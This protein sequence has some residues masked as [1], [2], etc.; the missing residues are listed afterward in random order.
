[1]NKT[2]I[3]FL[4][5]CFKV[6]CLDV[7]SQGERRGI[8]NA[9]IAE[10]IYLQLDKAIYTTGSTIWF[11]SIVTSSYNNSLTE[12]SSVLHVELIG[13][14]KNTIEKKLI[15]LNKGI[16]K[17]YLDLV[18][19]M[20]AGTYKIR[21]YTEW[22]KNF[23]QDFI[24]EKYIE[25]FS[26]YDEISKESKRYYQSTDS[27]AKPTTVPTTAYNQNIDLQFFPESGEMVNGLPSK[28]GFKAL[29]AYGKGIAVEGTILDNENN[30][31]SSFKSNGLGMGSFMLNQVD[32]S[33][34]YYAKL[35]KPDRDSIYT[36]PKIVATGSILSVI[37]KNN[38]IILTGISNHLISDSIH[39]KTATRGTELLD[40]KLKLQNGTFR[41]SIESEKL[42]EGIITFTLTDNNNHKIAERLYFNKRPK[43]NLNIK[44][45][46]DKASYS[47]RD[48]TN[49]SI[50][51]VNENGEPINANTSVLVINKEQLG[52]IQNSRDHILSYLLLSSELKGHIENPRYYFNESEDRTADLD[53][54]MLTQ[55]WRHYKYNKSLYKLSFDPERNLTISGKAVLTQ[56]KRDDL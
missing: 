55:G 34:K 45:T 39:L 38:V 10:K 16:G 46:T 41:F 27:I 13:D 53:A 4:I 15:K 52:A 42:P 37:E 12:V 51:T 31:V 36:L 50:K 1:M 20:P 24:F 44:I 56:G 11:K 18:D 26:I 28:V 49:L 30:I 17:G 54:L 2:C 43:N 48:L 21:A 8:S 7:Y 32:I 3:Y 19:T 9:S 33:K 14:Q 47:K 35:N 6:F 40:A 29:N 23:D 5:I 22:N 25:V